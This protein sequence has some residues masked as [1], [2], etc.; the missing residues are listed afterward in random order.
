LADADEI[1]DGFRIESVETMPADRITANDEDRQRQGFEIRTVFEWPVRDAGRLDVR[2]S[3]LVEGGEAFADLSFGPATLIRRFNVGLRRRAK[4]DSLGYPIN[5][6]SGYWLAAAEDEDADAI[7]DPSKVRP[8][9]IVP[10]VEDRKNALLIRFRG[11]RLPVETTATLQ[12]ALLRGIEMTFQLEEGEVLGEPLPSR[13]DRHAILIYEA[14][15]GGAGVLARL[16]KETETLRR[17]VD[18]AISICHFDLEYF[19]VNGRHVDALEDKGDPRCVA[20]CY[21]CLLSYYNQTDHEVI[22][23]RSQQFRLLLSR[24]ANAELVVTGTARATDG[25]HSKSDFAEALKSHGLPPADNRPI[26]IDGHLVEWIWRDHRF[27]VIAED[28]EGLV[29]RG[30]EDKGITFIVAAAGTETSE[31]VLAA[32]AEAI[33][34]CAS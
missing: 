9:N 3:Q 27:A 14:T 17:V 34:E 4:N 29:G 11:D 10:F 15:E 2:T 1:R 32:I 12:H 20:G 5:P 28:L 21:K 13:D 6:A 31:S 23:R 7:R 18:T 16:V 25:E 26:V 30:L 33:K 24:L 8:Q 22:D 19:Q